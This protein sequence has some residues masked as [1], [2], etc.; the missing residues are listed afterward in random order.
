MRDMTWETRHDAGVSRVWNENEAETGGTND[1]DSDGFGAKDKKKI[2]VMKTVNEYIPSVTERKSPLY[3]ARVP[4]Q[5]T[6]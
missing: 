4:A 5:W 3:P 6:S 1:A 2:K